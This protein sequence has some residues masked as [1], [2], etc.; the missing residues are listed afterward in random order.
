MPLTGKQRRTLRALGHHLKPVVQV[1]HSG[2]TE[3]LVAALEQALHDHE[4]VKVRVSEHA[5]GTRAEVA[6]ALAR[7]THSEVAQ[8]LGRT[9]LLYRA[10]PEEPR[11][12][13]PGGE[14]PS[15]P[16]RAR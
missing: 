8:V 16:R 5:A 7:A 2:V 11:I 9:V 13:L 10:R 14:P 3:A 1:G 15:P 6:A 12:V 4:L